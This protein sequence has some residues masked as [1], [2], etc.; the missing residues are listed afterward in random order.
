MKTSFAD[1]LVII[2][3]QI[4]TQEESDLVHQTVKLLQ[5]SL[6]RSE[7]PPLSD[8]LR[9]KLTKRLFD[10]LNTPVSEFLESNDSAGLRKFLDSLIKIIEQTEVI[11]INLAYEP[12]Q[13]GIR[14]ISQWIDSEI[15]KHA[16]IDINVDKTILGGISL[17]YRGRFWEKTLQQMISDVITQHREAINQELI[18]D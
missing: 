18:H 3:S 4:L 17:V 14:E 15:E 16:V 12:S 5:D 6:F 11:R 13:D 2:S 8:I 10:V 9:S 1:S 7:V